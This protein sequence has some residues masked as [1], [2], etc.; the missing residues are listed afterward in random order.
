V[1]ILVWKSVFMNVS[2]RLIRSV[3]LTILRETKFQRIS[4]ARL[5]YQSKSSPRNR[6]MAVLPPGFDWKNEQFNDT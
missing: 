3:S 4:P 1:A 5:S 6:R 2:I